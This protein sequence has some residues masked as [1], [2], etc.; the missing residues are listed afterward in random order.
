MLDANQVPNRWTDRISPGFVVIFQII[1]F[2]LLL[3]SVLI[4]NGIPP[5]SWVP[6]YAFEQVLPL[7]VPWAGAL[8]GMTISLVGVARHNH[9]WNAP[10][11]GVWHLLRPLLGGVSGTVAVLTLLFVLRTLE[12]T[13]DNSNTTPSSIAVMVVISF[14]VG[15]R[16][17]TFR[18]LIKRVV[19]VILSSTERSEPDNNLALAPAVLLIPYNGNQNGEASAYLTNI[20]TTELVLADAAVTVTAPCTAVLAD[21]A[22][23]APGDTRAITVSYPAGQA[24][25]YTGRLTVSSGGHTCVVTI[26]T[27]AVH[28]PAV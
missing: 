7:W 25:T 26:R 17:E 22:P 8:G 4:S 23:M 2:V 5:L 15:Y 9:E 16:E 28:P 1:V 12:A 27:S 3:A 13:P 6:R 21:S 20:G 19:D 11:Y 24:A 18:E 14:V 10:P